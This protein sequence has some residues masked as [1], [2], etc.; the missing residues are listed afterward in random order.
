MEMEKI[1]KKNSKIFRSE[2][3]QKLGLHFQVQVRVRVQNFT[4]KVIFSS[5]VDILIGSV[6]LK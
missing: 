6:I 3:V 1:E 5:L 4:Q 2:K